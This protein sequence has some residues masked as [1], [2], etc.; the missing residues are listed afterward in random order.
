MI[1]DDTKKAEEDEQIAEIENGD[2]TTL[3]RKEAPDEGSLGL[4]PKSLK[5]MIYGFDQVESYL[6]DALADQLKYI[7][8]ERR[9]LPSPVVAGPVV[10][11]L[12]FVVDQP[13]LREL[14]LNLLTTSMDSKTA[15][16]AHP[17]FVQM[18]K[19]MTPDEA[20]IVGLFRSKSTFPAVSLSVHDADGKGMVQVLVRH[21]SLLVYE[22]HCE[23]PDLATSYIDNLQ[24]LGLISVDSS[25]LFYDYQ[26]DPLLEHPDFKSWINRIETE[27]DASPSI[28]KAIVEVTQLGKQFRDACVLSKSEGERGEVDRPRI[29]SFLD[30]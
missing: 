21:F 29:L 3:I 14:Y 12:R 25:Q 13:F 10:D 15:R 22:A 4:L 6:K 1:E 26:Y 28:G 9:I 2:S 20:K 7:P 18:L 23:F 17:A 8:E 27:S 16:R 11:A 5:L 24:R 19:Q 30:Y